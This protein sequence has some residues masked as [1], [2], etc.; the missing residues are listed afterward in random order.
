MPDSRPV[1]HPKS[2]LT[3][4]QFIDCAAR[5]GLLCGLTGEKL[6]VCTIIYVGRVDYWV[7]NCISQRTGR[8]SMYAEG[9]DSLLEMFSGPN[10]L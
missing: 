7:V 4:Y 2:H 1:G 9:D 3:L 10:D 6:L 5:S 8:H